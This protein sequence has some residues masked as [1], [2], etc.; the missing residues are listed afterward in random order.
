MPEEYEG[1]RI[2]E[3][4]PPTVTITATSSPLANLPLQLPQHPSGSKSIEDVMERPEVPEALEPGL[5]T[6][7][8]DESTGS[9][10]NLKLAGIHVQERTTQ[11]GELD[12]GKVFLV[13][14]SDNDPTHPYS[15]SRTRRIA[16]TFILSLIG[17]IVGWAS[18]ID[19]TIV[20]KAAL[21]FG[22]GEID[23]LFST[24]K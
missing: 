19:S 1:E 23:E 8:T 14:Q 15:W 12:M 17:A 20:S 4:I 2:L 22:V 9:M 11:E 16:A 6:L 13:L 21:E 5:Q 18:S 24:G 7:T 10:L 3:G